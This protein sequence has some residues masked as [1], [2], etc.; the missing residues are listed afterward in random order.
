MGYKKIMFIIGLGI[1]SLLP[2]TG[3]SQSPKE[4]PAKISEGK[5]GSA[6]EPEED[7]QKARESFL[8]KDLK[9]SAAAIR[10]GAAYFM[11]LQTQVEEKREQTFYAS[12]EAMSKLADRVEKGTVKSV[13]ELDRVF[14]QTFHALAQYHYL[15]T[16]ES[17]AKKETTKAGQELE[18]ASAALARGAKQAGEKMKGKVGSVIEDSHLLAE[19]LIQGAGWAD[20]EA[21]KQIKAL[22]VEID[23]LGKKVKASK[24]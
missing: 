18:A 19:K 14:A 4:V 20:T 13:Q 3:V 5:V 9:A 7:F 24:K 23:K 8:K 6:T 1:V 17:W 15:K 2:G 21:E 10:K 22:G 16:M 12:Q 11:K